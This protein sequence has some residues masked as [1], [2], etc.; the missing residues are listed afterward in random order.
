MTGPE[1]HT[2][3]PATDRLT[4][5]LVADAVETLI[6]CRGGTT[7]DPTASISCLLS[8]AGE[9]E[10]QLHDAVADARD[11]GCSWEVIAQRLVSRES[12]V[13][14]RY[15]AYIRWRATTT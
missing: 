6:A 8:L 9:A 13:R 1:D 11:A 4:A 3:L 15:A 7:S 12:T 5:G 2:A 14:R 10:D